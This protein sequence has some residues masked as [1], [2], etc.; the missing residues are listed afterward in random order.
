[1]SSQTDLI[2]TASNIPCERECLLDC[3][4]AYLMPTTRKGTT[5]QLS[6]KLSSNRITSNWTLVF[7]I[8]WA[9]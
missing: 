3:W 6:I 2:D 9:N 7:S 5:V 4:L 8:L 1:M